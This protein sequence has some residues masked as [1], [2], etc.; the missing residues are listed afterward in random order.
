MKFHPFR[1]F[2]RNKV[3]CMATATLLAIGS[4]IFLPVLIDLVGG[5]GGSGPQNPTV[6][7]SRRFGKITEYDLNRFRNNQ[8]ALRRFLHVLYQNLDRKLEQDGFDT[9]DR[10]HALF[11][12]A[13]YVEEIAATQSPEFLVN[14]WL[15]TQYVQAEGLSPDWDDAKKLLE[16]LTGGPAPNGFLSQAIYD[17]TRQDVGISHDA[18]RQLLALQIQWRQALMRL[19]L[20]IG[21]ISPATRWDWYQR[22]YRNVTVEVAAVATDAFMGQVPEP[23]ERQLT[24]FFEQHKGQRFNPT[25]AESGFM[26]PAELAFQYVIAEPSQQLLDSIAEEDMLAFYEEHKD[27]W[28]RRPDTPMRPLPGMVPGTMP[29]MPGSTFPS[30]PTP[31][32]P[33]TPTIPGLPDLS[34]LPNLPGLDREIFGGDAPTEPTPNETEPAEPPVAEEA[35]EDAVEETPAPEISAPLGV[36]TRLVS[37]QTDEAEQ[38]N[39]VAE[40][41]V[42]GFHERGGWFGDS[43]AQPTETESVG[44]IVET[45]E[46]ML[47]DSRAPVALEEAVEQGRASIEQLQT[48]LERLEDAIE[49]MGGETEADLS[50]LF[51]PFDEVKDQ[52]REVLA[53][54]K[55]MEALLV[56]QEKMREYGNSYHEHFEQGKP[57][58]PMPDLSGFVA[59]QGLKLVTVPMGNIFEARKTEFARGI[60]EQQHLAQKFRRLPLL[61][62]G[63]IFLGTHAPILIWVTDEKQELR[64][65]TLKEVREVVL[66]RWKEVEARSLA[67]QKAEELADVARRSGRSL[68][69][70]FAGHRDVPVADTEPFTW[71]TSGDWDFDTTTGRVRQK[72]PSLGSVPERGVEPRNAEFGNRVIAAPGW[73]FMETVYSLQVGETGVVF[74]QPQTVAYIVRVTSSSPSADVLWEQFQ[75]THIGVYYAAGAQEMMVAS[76]EAW[77]DEIREKTGFRWVNRPDAR[78]LDQFEE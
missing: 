27:R 38:A 1:T 51:Q 72:P 7:E 25:I 71:M 48:A 37:Y 6:A 31:G 17:Q 15:V 45:I 2:Q 49:A 11:P 23:T 33:G 42:N 64:P 70:T 36:L 60:Q 46:A 74:N 76:F 44:S 13:G 10:R 21:T 30:F 78:A 62:D 63:E 32:R 34:D 57:T 67:M 18:V 55:A 66:Q 69:E 41:I 73:D 47:E 75:T 9:Q 16:D 59:S 43:T 29:G 77:L 19:N 58:P 52:I 56:I 28:F 5:G 3:G 22:L 40:P 26:M 24:A 61:F 14:M 39:T 35:D 50:I 68:T 8:E 4:F 53:Q 65:Q 12:L 20:S 54:D